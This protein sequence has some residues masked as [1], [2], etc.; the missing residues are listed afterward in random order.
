MGGRA[1]GA[2]RRAPNLQNTQTMV[3]ELSAGIARVD[4]QIAQAMNRDPL[5][6]AAT[7]DD[8]HGWWQ[9]ATLARRRA[10]VDALMLVVI[11]PIG[12]G[13]R[14]RTLEAAAETVTIEWR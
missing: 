2:G 10:V 8:V 5:A 6:E 13:R 1:G 9:A 4:A 14:V 3:D 7:G 12:H 11:Q